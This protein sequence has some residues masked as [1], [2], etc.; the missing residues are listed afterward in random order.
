MSHL[1]QHGALVFPSHLKDDLIQLLLTTHK[2]ILR[3]YSIPDPHRSLFSL[4]LH[5]QNDVE[6]LFY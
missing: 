6:D 1:L 2:G 5:T 4:L 3:I